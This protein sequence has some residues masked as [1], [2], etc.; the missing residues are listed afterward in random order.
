MH[1]SD[2]RDAARTEEA[3]HLRQEAANVGNVLDDVP[4]HHRGEVVRR[5]R[6]LHQIGDDDL[7]VRPLSSPV[8]RLMRELDSEAGFPAPRAREIQELPGPA[9]NVQKRATTSSCL[10]EVEQTSPRAP[11]VAVGVGRIAPADA[12]HG[13]SAL[14]SIE[15]FD[16]LGRRSRIDEDAHALPALEQGV[17]VFLERRDGVVASA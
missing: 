7:V 1:G 4:E 12:G 3:P 8:R 10:R 16:L 17:P 13:V 15:C 9:A 14:A 2:Q 6:V 11:G 5:H